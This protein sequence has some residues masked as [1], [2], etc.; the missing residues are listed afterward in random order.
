[1][2]LAKGSVRRRSCAV[3]A[4][5]GTWRIGLSNMDAY[6]RSLAERRDP[7]H[8]RPRTDEPGFRGSRGPCS[9]IVLIAEVDERRLAHC[10]MAA[11]LAYPNLGK[12]NG[13]R[14]P[15]RDGK[16][17]RTVAGSPRTL[18]KQA[19]GAL[20]DGRRP[21]RWRSS[22]LTRRRWK[23]AWRPAHVVGRARKLPTGS[24]HRVRQGRQRFDH[25]LGKRSK[26]PLP[27]SVAGG[28]VDRSTHQDRAA[29]RLRTVVAAHA[30]NV[31]AR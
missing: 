13:R 22:P 18:R 29:L 28:A 20:V 26:T 9:R 1:V 4:A 11:G 31:H 6:L 15:A 3:S 17:V 23:Q 30:A 8:A 24:M 7:R 14:K 16:V 5:C 19:E 21:G 27:G 2:F 10:C 12:A 25:Q